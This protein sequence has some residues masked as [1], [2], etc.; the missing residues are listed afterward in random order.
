[1]ASGSTPA[2]TASPGGGTLWSNRETGFRRRPI[3][4]LIRLSSLFGTCLRDVL[5][6]ALSR[7]RFKKQALTWVEHKES[8]F[9]IQIAALCISS[10]DATVLTFDNFSR[11]NDTALTSYGSNVTALAHRQGK[12]GRNREL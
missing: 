2:P 1:M 6:C 5:E 3:M 7:G 12:P 8:P 11:M 9:V 10:A 4:P